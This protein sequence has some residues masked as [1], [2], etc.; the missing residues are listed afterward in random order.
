[1]GQYFYVV[2]LT[3]KQYLDPHRFG[4]GAKLFEFGTGGGTMTGLSW[5]LSTGG[6]SNWGGTWAGD[7]IVIVGDYAKREYGGLYERCNEQF[8]DISKLVIEELREVGYA[9]PKGL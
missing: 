1:M 7:S 3:K 4:D 6:G 8:L 5:L 9:V 2:N